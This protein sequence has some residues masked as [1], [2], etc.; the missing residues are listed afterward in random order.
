MFFVLSMSPAKGD[1]WGSLEPS[2]AFAEIWL[3][4]R[5]GVPGIDGEE[6]RDSSVEKITLD[7]GPAETKE[8][9]EP[10]ACGQSLTGSTRVQYDT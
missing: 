7:P 3:F 8:E 2:L 6:G 9:I 10:L 4:P 1:S 5:S